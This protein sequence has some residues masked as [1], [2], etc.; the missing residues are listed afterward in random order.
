MTKGE[1]DDFAGRVEFRGS[2]DKYECG[3][4]I[5]SAELADDGE[6]SCEITMKADDG[7]I[8]KPKAK[9]TVSV[10]KSTTTETST[11]TTPT[12]TT[13]TTIQR[14]NTST[15]QQFDKSTNQQINNSTIQQFNNSTI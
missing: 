9:F 6:W 14:H 7:E 2:H 13:P 15:I 1:C 3:L 10:E 11:T 4:E 5:S 8:R 12:T